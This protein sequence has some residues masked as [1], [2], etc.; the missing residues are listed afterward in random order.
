MNSSTESSFKSELHILQQSESC[1]RGHLARL[2]RTR[3]CWRVWGTR[4]SSAGH[5]PL[6][7]HNLSSMG[8]RSCSSCF[9]PCFHS[10]MAGHVVRLATETRHAASGAQMKTKQKKICKVE[11]TIDEFSTVTYQSTDEKYLRAHSLHTSRRHKV[12]SGH[13]A[14]GGTGCACKIRAKVS[15]RRQA[16]GLWP[17]DAINPRCQP[18]PWDFLTHSKHWKPRWRPDTARRVILFLNSVLLLRCAY[19]SDWTQ[20][21]SFGDTNAQ[22]IDRRGAQKSPRVAVGWLQASWMTNQ[23]PCKLVLHDS[24]EAKVASFQAQQRST[25]GLSAFFWKLKWI[26]NT[27]SHQSGWQSGLPWR[28]EPHCSRDSMVRE[29]AEIWRWNKREREEKKDRPRSHEACQI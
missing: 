20:W 9:W 5:L 28:L 15:W 25:V 11:P 1:S 29:E 23:T 24:M 26:F 21:W 18:F 7:A 6:A 19:A 2:Q 8:P 4:R 13:L 16:P 17:K 14:T 22:M 10:Y 12:Q 27:I 3:P